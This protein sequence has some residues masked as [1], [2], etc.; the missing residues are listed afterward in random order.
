MRMTD[1]RKR[2]HF[3]AT[4][5]LLVYGLAPVSGGHINPAVS[6][7]LM[8]TKKITA[9]R[10]VAYIIAQCGGAIVGTLIAS[11]LSHDTYKAAGGG[12]NAPGAGYNAREALVAEIMGTA[13]LMF[14][15]YTAVDPH[16]AGKVI[17]IGALGPAAI[18]A[19]H[20]HTPASRA[21]KRPIAVADAP[22]VHDV[23]ACAVFQ[24]APC[25]RRTWRC[26]PLTA[27]PSTR[28]ARSAPRLCTG[29]GV[30]TG[31]SGSD[32]SWARLCPP[33]STSCASKRGRRRL[34]RRR[35]RREGCMHCRR[36]LPH[37]L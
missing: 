7:G 35:R 5:V 30:S 19:Q 17:H 16:R 6:F 10:T 15:V 25:L 36:V 26:F 8:L 12:V 2:C 33:A 32:R 9:I 20:T 13:L 23:L 14:T 22:R 37:M 21:V 11:S 28:R 24:A 31:Y 18:G 3:S 34:R 1:P 29:S 4:A 27:R